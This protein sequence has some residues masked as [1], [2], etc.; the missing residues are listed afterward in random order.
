MSL[1][2]QYQV[3]NEMVF[4]VQRESSESAQQ[5]CARLIHAAIIS[6]TFRQKLLANPVKSVEAGYCGEKF[7]FTREEKAR[8]KLIQAIT[9]DE[10]ARQLTQVVEGAVVPQMAYAR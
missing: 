1:L 5:E 9:L 10:F 8:M 2:T 4:P 7:Y 6:R 3:K